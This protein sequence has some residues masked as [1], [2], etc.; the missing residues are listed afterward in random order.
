MKTLLDNLKFDEKGLLPAIIQDAAS[1][2][3]LMCAYMNREA[4]ELTMTTG[5]THFWSRSRNKFWPKGEESGNFQEVCEVFFDCDGDTLLIKVRQK[6]GA[7]HEG[8]R[9]CF[10]RKISK[11]GEIEIVGKKIFEPEKVYGDAKKEN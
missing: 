2:E 4:V 9:S 8:Y 5:R 3:V 10:Y 1:G 7:C 6:G 11:E